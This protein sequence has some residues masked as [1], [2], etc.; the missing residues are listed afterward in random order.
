LRIA[1]DEGLDRAQL[2]ELQFLSERELRGAIR[3][4][5]PFEESGLGTFSQLHS[6]RQVDELFFLC[7]QMLLY[8]ERDLLR[9][10]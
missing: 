7:S 10:P 4:F 9:E 5:T 2:S 6:I 3:E 1:L 8:F